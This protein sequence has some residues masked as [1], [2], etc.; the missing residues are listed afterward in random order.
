MGC[1]QRQ[2]HV[3]RVFQC[4]EREVVTQDSPSRINDDKQHLPGGVSDDHKWQ[5]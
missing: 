2:Q 1:R 3:Q 5:Q 4:R